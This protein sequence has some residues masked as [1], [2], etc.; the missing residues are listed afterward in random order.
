MSR[1]KLDTHRSHLDL[2]LLDE[3]P[4]YSKKKSY[5]QLLNQDYF[6]VEI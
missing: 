6:S 3:N 4:N 1:Y 5:L 2:K